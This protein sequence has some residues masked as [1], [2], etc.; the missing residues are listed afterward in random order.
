MVWEELLIYGL[1]DMR[2]IMFTASEE[3]R[4]EHYL[5]YKFGLLAERR[6]HL[7]SHTQ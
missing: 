5:G 3:G 7:K 1:G 4:L 2:D 6:E